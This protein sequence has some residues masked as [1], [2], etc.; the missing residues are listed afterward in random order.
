MISG[1]GPSVLLGII[2]VVSAWALFIIQRNLFGQK[3]KRNAGETRAEG[4]PVEAEE[5][6]NVKSAGNLESLCIKEA[7]D[8]PLKNGDNIQESKETSSVQEP[9]QEEDIAAR[10]G[11]TSPNEMDLPSVDGHHTDTVPGSNEHLSEKSQTQLPKKATP[12][13]GMKTT[14][15]NANMDNAWEPSMEKTEVSIM[16]AT[17]NDEW[18]K[19]LDDNSGDL[20][21]GES[22]KMHDMQLGIHTDSGSK[23]GALGDLDTAV[24]QE[25]VQ[26]SK[27][28]LAVSPMP[29]NVGVSFRVHY[30]TCSP[31]QLIAVTGN[32]RELG[33][34]EN[35]VPLRQDKNGF[36][37]NSI[38][39]PAD[40]KMEWKF[41]MVENGK[42]K[43]WEECFNRCLETTNDDI[44]AHTCWGYHM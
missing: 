17:M 39:L 27:K 9:M 1:F 36:W 30:I 8:H 37:C 24:I 44:K 12:V 10:T 6:T 42:I 18:M 22:T 31:F 20:N 5:K 13:V 21:G 40:V 15:F 7:T 16:E 35:Y 29:Q 11:S 43:R 2:V 4:L 25:S 33:N 38:T 23:E 26:T 41:V 3:G 14:G 19:G 28:I 32:H 34:W